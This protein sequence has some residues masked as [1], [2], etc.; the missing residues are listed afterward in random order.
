MGCLHQILDNLDIHSYAILVDIYLYFKKQ[1][2][3]LIQII[4][5]ALSTNVEVGDR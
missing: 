5:L 2:I 4:F 3:H 1:I